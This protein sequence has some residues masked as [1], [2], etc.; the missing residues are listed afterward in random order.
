MAPKAVDAPEAPH[1]EQTLS[2]PW[3]A[4][5]EPAPIAKAG[6]ASTGGYTRGPPLVGTPCGQAAAGRQAREVTMSRSNKCLPPV[7]AQL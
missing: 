5:T 2:R 7:A 6:G 3:A 1:P 4:P